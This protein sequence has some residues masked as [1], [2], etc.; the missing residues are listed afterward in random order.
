MNILIMAGGSGERFWPISHP[1]QP[2]QLLP[3]VS[4]KPMIEETVDRLL[5]IVDYQHIFISTNSFLMPKIRRLLPAIPTENYVIEPQARD[6]AA[7]I[8]LGVIYIHK[9][10]PGSVMA[11]LPADHVILD[12]E[13]FTQELKIAGQIAQETGC[14]ITLGIKPTRPETGYGYIEIG[15]MINNAHENHAFEVKSF[16]EKPDV[17]KA[18][19]YI[20]Q[21]NFFWNSGIFLWSTNVIL[22]AMENYLP[23]LFNGLMEIQDYMGLP[24]EQN[25]VEEQ[26]KTF[27]KISIDYGIMEKANNVLCVKARF[28]WD[29]VGNWTALERYYPKDENNNIL[30]TD[31]VGWDTSDSMIFND[32]GLIGTIG[33]HNHIIVKQGDVV[34]IIDKSRE[35]DIKKIIAQLKDDENLKK[36][37]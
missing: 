25:I 10:D 1:S 34:L 23:D 24:E 13:M 7:A 28:A 20:Q 2:K 35:Q 37:L 15:E 29:D 30:K 8:G 3:I 16:K 6:T 22:E 26:F 33:I 5:G 31:W 32:K 4:N 14:L 21:G 19:E 18:N 27:K 11:V 17:Q 9:R 36:Y 12:K